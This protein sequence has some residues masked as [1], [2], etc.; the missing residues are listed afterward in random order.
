MGSCDLGN[1][2]W[3]WIRYPVFLWRVFN[4]SL[5]EQ[6][7]EFVIVYENV[8]N[9]F[10]FQNQINLKYA[11]REELIEA[12]HTYLFFGYHWKNNWI[13]WSKCVFRIELWAL[14]YCISQGTL[15]G[16]VNYLHLPF[17]SS[18][19]ILSRIFPIHDNIVI[20]KKV[21]CKENNL[22]ETK[23]AKTHFVSASWERYSC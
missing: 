22:W 21:L 20:Y 12:E 4:C 1:C 18:S 14:V 11:V 16:I 15:N 19:F 6:H 2:L 13:L 7:R 23:Q 9:S 8:C 17:C 10:L 5:K 3:Y